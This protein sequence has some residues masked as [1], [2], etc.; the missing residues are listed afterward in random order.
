MARGTGP[1]G[2]RSSLAALHAANDVI[3]RVKASRPTTV[4]GHVVTLEAARPVLVD[5]SPVPRAMLRDERSAD[6]VPVIGGPSL[7]PPTGTAG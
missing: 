3:A 4:G 5:G 7:N 2:R 6:A 1:T